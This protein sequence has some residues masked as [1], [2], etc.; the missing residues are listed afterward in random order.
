MAGGLFGESVSVSADGNTAIIGFSRRTGPSGVYQGSAYVYVRSGSTWT[1]QT[2][3][4]ANDGVSYDYFGYAVDL[5]SDGNTAI[6]GAFGKNV[7]AS[8]DGAAYVFTRSGAT[9]SQQARL[10]HDDPA[11]NDAFGGGVSISSNGNTAL[12]SA[13]G[14]QGTYLQQGAAYVFTRS[15]TTWSQQAKLV[16][17]DPGK[18][19]NFGRALVISGDGNTALLSA[20]NK[21]GTYGT[22]GAVYIFTLSGSAWGQQAKLL[23]SDPSSY[24]DTF[25]KGVSLSADGNMAL[26]GAPGWK[27]SQNGG[28]GIVYYF[29][30]SGST[31]TQ[32]QQV[33]PGD[34]A[35]SDNF[36]CSI[37][38]SSD[39][40][41]ALIGSSGK[42][43]THGS[44]GAAYIFS[45]TGNNWT[46]R[47]RFVASDPTDN[48]EQYGKV[49]K[50]SADAGTGIV[51]TPNKKT[52]SLADG[53][54]YILS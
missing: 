42:T 34:I 1:Q 7:N 39:G 14:K 2:K 29:T 44:Q 24:G 45:R 11:T 30:R 12:I 22:Q 37:S 52:T 43:I 18:N 32:Q 36:G 27:S 4:L 21:T 46:Q 41:V 31:W 35:P 50:L 49:V 15:G 33:F 9:W 28:L 19:D 16:S 6:V 48:S 38:L 54:A 51:G 3:L 25:G 13:G 20:Y 10:T 5:S 40:S 26:I 23:A 8:G 47:V 53:A 17:S